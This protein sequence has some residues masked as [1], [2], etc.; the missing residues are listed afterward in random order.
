MGRSEVGVRATAVITRINCPENSLSISDAQ[1]VARAPQ[2][3]SGFC[4]ESLAVLK[5]SR[6]H[7]S[8]IRRPPSF[9]VASNVEPA[10]AEWILAFKQF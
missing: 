9:S 5:T 3:I 2:S 7:F 4:N 6:D 10:G 8:D 1:A